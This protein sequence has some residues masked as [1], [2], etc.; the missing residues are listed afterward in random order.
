MTYW[1]SNLFVAH[2]L[3]WQF[4]WLR[5][6]RLMDS[7]HTNYFN[8]HFILNICNAATAPMDGE[9]LIWLFAYHACGTTS[10]LHST[11][12]TC[13]VQPFHKVAWDCPYPIL[14]YVH[15]LLLQQY[16]G[17]SSL[18]GD[19]TFPVC[20]HTR[21]KWRR[22]RQ[23]CFFFLSSAGG[24]GHLHAELRLG[25]GFGQCFFVSHCTLK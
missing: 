3:W 6:L 7:V 21:Q 5:R 13:P 22:W 4:M 8:F 10:S 2:Y 19:I 24:H 18:S 11:Q 9:Q 25:A 23:R 15:C 14:V 1:R 17:K 12:T 20:K 16:S